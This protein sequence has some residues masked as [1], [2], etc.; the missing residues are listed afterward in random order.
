MPWNTET[1]IWLE[2]PG[3]YTIKLTLT[4]YT[5]QVDPNTGIAS[6]PVSNTGEKIK[7]VRVL[8]AGGEQ[9]TQVSQDQNTNKTESDSSDL[10]GQNT[11]IGNTTTIAAPSF[12]ASPLSGQAPLDVN[13]SVNNVNNPSSTLTYSWKANFLGGPTTAPA[14]PPGSSSKV[15][16]TQA[17]NYSVT[18]TATDNQGNSSKSDEKII[19]VSSSGAV[20]QNQN[21]NQTTTPPVA[22]FR[23]TPNSNFAPVTVTLDGSPSSALIGRTINSYQWQS[24]DGQTIANIERTSITYQQPGTYTIYLTVKDDLGLSSTTTTKTITVNQAQVSAPQASFTATPET[25]FAPLTVSLD[26]SGSTSPSGTINSYL[27]QSNDGQTITNAQKNSIT[28]TQ[29]GS[30]T[31]SLTVTDSAG[32]SSTTTKNI[33]VNEAPVPTASFTATPLSG[34]A[35]LTVS[36]DGSGSTSSSGN[37]ITGYQWQSSD[38]QNKN[39]Q[40]TSMTYNQAG[41]HT[42][43]LTVTDSSNLSSTTTTETIV[44]N[45]APV[46]TARFTAVPTNGLES[47]T[48]NLDASNSTGNGITYQWTRNDGI[49]INETSPTVSTTF[50]NG[51]TYTIT[52][53]ITDQSGKQDQDERTI[54]VVSKL[55]PRF[56]VATNSALLNNYTLD[57]SNSTVSSNTTYTWNID[58]QAQGNESSLI[59]T[60]NEGTHQL[61]LALSV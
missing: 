59:T 28:Y 26:G 1:N 54:S 58:Q 31:I 57:A 47:L 38:E 33:T 39:G 55:K 60:L 27:W 49:A 24:N 42:I 4:E 18:V 19:N 10:T 35:P 36:L 25:G 56:T 6:I 51:G 9:T 29:A 45:E 53:T 16:L 21:Q 5:L 14:I 50:E 40:T 46:P 2:T 17:G 41:T 32:L 12:T 8:P 43:S 11:S 52:L 15:T 13:L 44:V 23:A 37:A 34:V 61:E 7:T 3:E 20:V 30:H 22:N 48:V